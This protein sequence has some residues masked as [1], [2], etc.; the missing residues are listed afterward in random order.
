MIIDQ[1]VDIFSILV[2]ANFLVGTSAELLAEDVAAV[3]TIVFEY[4]Q[5]GRIVA[6]RNINRRLMNLRLLRGGQVTRT[7]SPKNCSMLQGLE[8]CKSKSFHSTTV[9]KSPTHT[10][11]K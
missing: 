9:G 1:L 7:E 5:D 4:V 11:V 3:P 6:T 8:L 10:R 2:S